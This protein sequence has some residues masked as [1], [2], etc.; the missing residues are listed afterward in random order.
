MAV[1]KGTES[2]EKTTMEGATAGPPLKK[3]RATKTDLGRG[4]ASSEH[5][6]PYG[7][8]AG[9]PKGSRNKL[10]E[11]F[12]SALCADFEEHGDDVLRTLRETQPAVYV[13]VIASL[14]PTQVEAH[15]SIVS[16]FSDEQVIQLVADLER[17][18]HNNPEDGEATYVLPPVSEAES[19]P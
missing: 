15:A 14:L 2:K 16:S 4:Y 13:R 3:K 7:H 11:R 9:R 10:S 5:W 6:F 17:W 19:V 1:R 18:V 12:L 8:G